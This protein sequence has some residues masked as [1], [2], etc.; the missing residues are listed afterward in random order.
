EGADETFVNLA[1]L[2]TDGEQLYIPKK[3]EAPVAGGEGQGAPAAGGSGG[4]PGGSSVGG[5]VGGA[6]N[7][8]T[9]DATQLETLP[10]IGPAMAER[11]ISWR[12]DN[13]AFTSV[14]DLLSVAGIGQKTLE[15]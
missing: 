11:I 15:S 3:G 5:T 13:G 2:V 4:G 14:D 8:N 9:A 1:R 6:V 12:E 7:I 10:G